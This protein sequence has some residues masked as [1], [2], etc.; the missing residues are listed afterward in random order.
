MKECKSFWVRWYDVVHDEDVTYA[1]VVGGH[2]EACIPSGKVL[3]IGKDCVVR[4]VL[5]AYYGEI[6]KAFQRDCS[7]A[8]LQCK[9]LRDVSLK[10]TRNGLFKLFTRRSLRTRKPLSK[11]KATI[12][13]EEMIRIVLICF[14]SGYP[15]LTTLA[16]FMI[17]LYQLAGRGAE[18]ALIP[19]RNVKMTLPQEF[20][21]TGT[22]T[23][24]VAEISLM[25]VKTYNEQQLCIFHERETISL[26][27]GTFLL[28]TP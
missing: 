2:N 19:F 25:R 15:R 9:R 21:D 11:P 1:L 7:R 3:C 20:N 10:E 27:I 23:D 24:K 26:L 22:D 5:L 17:T 6:A 4:N 8:G 13:C 18:V 16:S 28:G 12:T 14:W